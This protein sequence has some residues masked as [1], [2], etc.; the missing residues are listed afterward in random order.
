[1]FM[2]I[3]GS[4]ALA[5][6]RRW[7]WSYSSSP[8]EAEHPLGDDVALD[9]GRAGIDRLC[10]RP[11]PGVLPPPVLDR[12][13]GARSER[14]VHPLH[15]D[16]GLL[17]PLVH[18]APV[19]LR[20]AGLRAGRVAVLGA[21]EV[22]QADEPE[23]VGLDLRLRDPLAHRGVS[24][25]A[26]VTRQRGKL[27][28]RALEAGRLGQAAALEAEDGHRDLPAVR[29]L[30]YQVAVLDLG[31]GE[32]DLAELAAAGHLLDAPDLDA[33]LM[34]V[35][36]EETDAAVWLGRL[37]GGGEKKAPVRIVGAPR[38]G[39]LAPQHP[40]AVAPLGPG[41]QACQIAASV[42]LAEPLAEDQLTA[43]DLLHVLL[44]LPL[45]PHRHE[46][47][48]QQRHAKAAEDA[49]GARA[50]HLLLV[51]GLHHRRRAATAG[52]HR[53]AELQPA[54]LV[55]PALPFALDLG[56]LL[57]AVPP[58]AVL[59]P[60]RGEVG[61]EPRSD[62]VSEAFFFA[63]EAEIHVRKLAKGGL[64]RNVRSQA[65]KRGKLDGDGFRGSMR[66]LRGAPH[67][68]ERAVP[69]LRVAG[70]WQLRRRGPAAQE[71]RGRGR[72]G[73]RPWAWPLLS[74]PQRQ[75]THLPSGRRRAPVL[76]PGPG[77]VG[78]RGRGRCSDGARRWG[79]VA[80]QHRRCL[81]HR[82]VHGARL[83][84]SLTPS[85]CG[86]S[87]AASVRRGG[88]APARRL[89]A[90][91]ELHATRQR[92]DAALDALSRRRLGRP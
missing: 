40:S 15:A 3:A 48:R 43:E 16:R 8:G 68:P 22:A 77:S 66:A 27:V 7:T 81:P 65:A 33:R 24:T 84:A 72:A 59:A 82:Q 37:V 49:G 31:P 91:R 58:F 35:D 9:L 74:R 53:P 21:G 70:F 10:L 45:A 38:P 80:F 20:D 52:F 44:L 63:R 57:F 23:D 5:G 12:L 13:I 51:D 36:E 60:G 19:K 73:D 69:A 18:L 11:H 2:L 25:H 64:W 89:A 39:L 14:P 71:S 83:L 56:V 61:A 47:R 54:A 90:Q 42:G 41:A 32:E 62:L 85:G 4:C 92:A 78:H 87:L 26:A 29:G 1:M 46:R 28:D 67:Q 79:P 75:R 6:G 17:Q 88:A 86:R 55:K 76:R 50:N 30:P 34:H